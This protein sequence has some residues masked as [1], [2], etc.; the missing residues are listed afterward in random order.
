VGS[1]GAVGCFSF[2]PTKTLGAIGDAGLV[3]ASNAETAKRLGLLR[4]YGWTQPQFA[5][6]PGGRC[7]RLDEIQ[8]AILNVKLD[9]VAAAVERRRAIAQRYNAAFAGL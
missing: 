4:T 8:A 5:E 2:Y 7:S 6:I 3:T 9:H 1:I